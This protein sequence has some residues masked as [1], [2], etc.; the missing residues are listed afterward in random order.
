MIPRDLNAIG[1]ALYGPRF[2]APLASSLEIAERT[3]RRWLVG[4]WP[5][6]EHVL[7]NCKTLI[8]A[9]RRELADLLAKEF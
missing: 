8:R 1:E 7:D 3:L 5:I 4:E 2:H 9:K 6:P